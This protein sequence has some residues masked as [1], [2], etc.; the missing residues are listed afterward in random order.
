MRSLIARM[1]FSLVLV[2][3]LGMSAAA[4]ASADSQAPEG[5]T[6]VVANPNPG[7]MLTPGALVIEGVAFD[8]SATSGV[9]IDR[10]SVFLD[11]RDTGGEHL[12]DAT[13]GSQSMMP[14][15]AQFATSGWVL[16]TPVLKGTG[17]SHN[18]YVYARSAVT[19]QETV[20]EIPIFIGEKA[21]SATPFG[22]S[23]VEPGEPSMPLPD[24]GG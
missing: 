5:P 12:G 14:T 24:Y 1:S 22:T 17:E 16:T 23:H 3:V 18:L 4:A 10:V 7:D 21:D 2:A 13:L 19:G 15:P 8:G 11:N 20:S 9:G 6:L